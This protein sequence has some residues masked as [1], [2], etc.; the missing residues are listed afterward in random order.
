MSSTD[1]ADYNDSSSTTVTFPPGETEAFYRVSILDDNII[2][3]D[4]SFS[5]IL[6]T[7]SNVII[8]DGIVTVTILDED[9]R[10]TQHK[11]VLCT[12]HNTLV[13]ATPLER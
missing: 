11:V 1:G 9:G 8:G 13:S 7:E 5:V 6:T 4:K 2:E 12:L 10:F 3:P